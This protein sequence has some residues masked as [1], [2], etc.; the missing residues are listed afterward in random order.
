MMV[1]PGVIHYPRLWGG[2]QRGDPCV[3]RMLGHSEAVG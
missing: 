1:G 2:H 3:V